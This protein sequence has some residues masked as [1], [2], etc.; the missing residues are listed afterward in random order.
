MTNSLWQRNS[1]FSIP[2]NHPR[3][4]PAIT[5]QRRS[6]IYLLVQLLLLGSTDSTAGRLPLRISFGSATHHV[7]SWMLWMTISGPSY[8]FHVAMALGKLVKA[9]GLFL[10][11]LARPSPLNHNSGGTSSCS[12]S[13]QPSGNQRNSRIARLPVTCPSALSAHGQRV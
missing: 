4:A 2:M 5:Q 6:C 11:E 7:L 13:Y 1:I 12:A 3:A 9:I 8:A 10:R